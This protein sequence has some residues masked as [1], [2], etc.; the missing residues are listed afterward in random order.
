MNS[1]WIYRFVISV[2][3]P[4]AALG[5]AAGQAPAQNYP[6]KPVSFIVPYGPGTGN[7][8]IARILSQKVGESW[9]QPLVVDNR[10]GAA[11]AIGTELAARAAPDGHTILIASTSQLI[12]PY[13]SRVRYDI[14]KDFTAVVVPGTLPY[15]LAVPTASP[16]A[17]I[18]E[19]VAQA[20]AM[21]GKFN[22]AGSF[23]SVSHF[24]GEMLKTAGGI[25]IA[26]IT[27]KGTP[28]AIADVIAN[29][30]QIWFTT[31]ATGTPLA[32]ADKIRVLGVAGKKRAAVLPDVPTMAEAGYP[33]LDVSASFYVLAPAAT[34]KPVVAAL[35]REMVK[36]LATQ[37]VKDKLGAAGVE[38]NSTTPEEAGTLLRTEVAGW[39]KVVRESGVEMK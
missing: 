27:Y 10:S 34:P 2:L 5:L 7:D 24:M 4:A 21:P 1:K 35:N 3:V 39:G 8:I 18:K 37:E 13:I 26:L 31:M 15:L 6:G 22:Y 32:K 19:L 17:S 25:D 12:N 14:L 16:A 9:S 28:D 33:T 30:V 11:G 29:R 20:K 36:A 38:I 23:G